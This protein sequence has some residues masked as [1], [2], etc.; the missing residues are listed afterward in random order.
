[1]TF[2]FHKSVAFHSSHIKC[3]IIEEWMMTHRMVCQ[4]FHSFS[5]QWHR[6]GISIQESLIYVHPGNIST[7]CFTWLY[8]IQWSGK[9]IS[10]FSVTLT[11]DMVARHVVHRMEKYTF[12]FLR[13]LWWNLV[14]ACK[15]H[16]ATYG[17][18]QCGEN[19]MIFFLCDEVMRYLRRGVH[20]M[21]NNNVGCFFNSNFA[22][23][24]SAH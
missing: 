11:G 13:S 4:H 24:C 16:I 14:N 2:L 18:I 19:K 10:F 17:E 21:E 7:Y 20:R 22:Q 6:E 5:C 1:M 3:C 15:Q 8:L 23:I 9:L 12:D